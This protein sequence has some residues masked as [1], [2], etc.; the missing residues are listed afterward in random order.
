MDTQVAQSSN[1]DV[2]QRLPALTLR[3]MRYFVTLARVLSFGKAA[4]QIGITSP[5][6]SHSIAETER[7]LDARL[8]EREGREV[9]LSE[10][11]KL[12]L[13]LVQRLLNTADIT[14]ADMLDAAKRGEYTVHVGLVPS[15]ASMIM[16]LLAELQKVAPHIRFAF[17]DMPADRVA[18]SVAAGEIDVGIGVAHSAIG[19]PME[20]TPLTT[21]EIVAVVRKDDPLSKEDQVSWD[22]L[23]DRNIGHFVSGGIADLSGGAIVS[24][25]IQLHPRYQVRFTETLFAMVE[26]GLCVGIVPQNTAHFLLTKD[27][28]CL[29]I[30]D[31]VVYREL[32]VMRLKGEPRTVAVDTCFKFLRKQH[33]HDFS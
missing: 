6:L 16:K 3:H 11:G 18:A 21:D 2:V 20:T 17:L 25:Q 8:F 1:P 9:E 29:R 30:V 22:R 14:I 31:P 5:A 33:T 7:L 24:R 32:V 27:L 28:M 19:M 4:A 12:V 13:P 10:V 23:H 26:A 15:M